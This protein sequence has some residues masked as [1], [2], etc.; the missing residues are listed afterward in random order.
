MSFLSVM[1]LEVCDKRIKAEI[2]SGDSAGDH[3]GRDDVVGIAV[4]KV[5]AEKAG[6]A[7]DGNDLALLAEDRLIG[8]RIGEGE[9]G[10]VIILEGAE[11]FRSRDDLDPG[12]RFIAGEERGH[13]ESPTLRNKFIKRDGRSG[14]RSGG[15]GF[16]GIVISKGGMG[17]GKCFVIHTGDN[18]GDI[19]AIIRLDKAVEGTT[20]CAMQRYDSKI[21]GSAGLNVIRVHKNH[22]YELEDRNNFI[23]R[24]SRWGYGVGDLIEEGIVG[25]LDF[26]DIF[27]GDVEGA[28]I[29]GPD[30]D[31][32]AV[33]FV[34]GAEEK[35]DLKFSFQRI[36]IRASNLFYGMEF[37]P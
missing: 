32:V 18:N 8:D 22:L 4:R 9:S 13:E 14:E 11:H 31:V 5:E 10:A 29:I 23:K 35:D 26:G 12:A 24:N 21:D 34:D 3:A 1:G 33:I 16:G 19:S 37:D 20:G 30:G 36:V 7:E 17:G 27:M 28:G 6:F 15:D 25:V 2:R